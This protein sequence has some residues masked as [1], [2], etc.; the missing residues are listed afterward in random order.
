MTDNDELHPSGEA[1]DPTGHLRENAS[2]PGPS[3]VPTKSGCL[4]KYLWAVLIGA[5]IIGLSWAVASE[6]ELFAGGSEASNDSATES[7]I[8]DQGAVSSESAS[9]AEGSGSN[10]AGPISGTWAMY[11][12]G[13]DNRAFEITFTGSDT[14]T[15]EIL[16]DDTESLTSFTVEGDQV[17]FKFTRTFV[18]SSGKWPEKSTF[19]GT[20][21]GLHEMTGTWARQDWECSPDGCKYGAEWSPYDARLIRISE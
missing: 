9:D 10:T 8:T 12:E 2:D 11:W 1:Q 14:G 16:N 4:V 20:L 5:G 7:T 6:L 19:E 13:S 15:L 18:V 21:T 17:R 3:D